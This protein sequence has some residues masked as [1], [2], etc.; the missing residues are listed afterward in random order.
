MKES[1]GLRESDEL[2]NYETNKN[3]L[4][5]YFITQVVSKVIH[6]KE[7]VK[8]RIQTKYSFQIFILFQCPLTYF[9]KYLSLLT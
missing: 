2:K 7:L 4:I 3:Q 8:L 6:V 5:L 9:F 1:F